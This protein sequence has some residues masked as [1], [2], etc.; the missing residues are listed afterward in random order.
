VIRKWLDKLLRRRDNDK[1]L[2]G[3]LT[4]SGNL[5]IKLI[6]ANKPTRRQRVE[7]FIARLLGRYTT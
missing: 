7:D 1:A 5:G 4:M 3:V 6:R 2:R